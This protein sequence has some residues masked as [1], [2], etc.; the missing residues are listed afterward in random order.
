MVN[1]SFATYVDFATN[2]GNPLYLHPSETPTTMLATLVL[3]GMKN[4]QPWIRSM[5]MSLISRNK[6]SF[7]DGT[8][9]SPEKTNSTFNQWTCCNSMVLSWIQRSVSANV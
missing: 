4:F 9:K 8:F 5:R 7:V 1:Q 6:I 2:N 3:E